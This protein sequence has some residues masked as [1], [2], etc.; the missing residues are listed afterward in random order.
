MAIVYRHRRLDTNEIFYIGIGKEEKRAFS[1]YKRNVHWINIVKKAGYQVEIISRDLTWEDACE[2]E[3]FLIKLYGRKD[4]GLGNLVNMTDGGDGCLGNIHSE[5]T[6]KLI[7]LKLK[8]NV[9]PNKTSFISGQKPWNKDLK[10][11]ES[12]LFN[13]KKTEEHKNNISESKKGIS[14]TK[15]HREN[16]SKA[17][18]AS[19]KVRG[20]NNPA[21]RKVINLN[22]NQ[23]FNTVKETSIF[24]KVSVS[25]VTRWLNGKSKNKYNLKYYE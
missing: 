4:L 9:K 13:V 22:S 24:Y 8:G 7:S 16:L 25:T 12:F 14:L 18:K 20:G 17:R 21:A 11:T 1:K 3:I 19:L 10:G 5:E 15:E 2:L 6:R 23:V